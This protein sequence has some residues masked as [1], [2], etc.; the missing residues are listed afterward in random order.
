[1][2]PEAIQ[3]APGACC[4][5][6]QADRRQWS[7]NAQIAAPAVTAPCLRSAS[8][9]RGSTRPAGRSRA[10][11]NEALS[12]RKD[13]ASSPSADCPAPPARRGGDFCREKQTT[14]PLPPRDGR[15]KPHLHKSELG[16]KG[17]SLNT[18]YG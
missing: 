17:G 7:G 15:T 11:H 16:E 3:A 2:A 4:N 12:R 5:R 6:G 10:R 14:S 13:R 9:R 8:G 18:A 1:M